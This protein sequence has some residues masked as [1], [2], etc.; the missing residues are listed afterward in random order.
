MRPESKFCS[1]SK[2]IHFT[3]ILNRV[4]TELMH[5]RQKQRN[6]N[7]LVSLCRLTEDIESNAAISVRKW[8]SNLDNIHSDLH[9]PPR[10]LNPVGNLVIEIY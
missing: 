2:L 5:F 9:R 8:L 6:I 10:F 3:T 7:P 1:M 4:R